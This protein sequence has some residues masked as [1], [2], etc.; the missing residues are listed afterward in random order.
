MTEHAVGTQYRSIDYPRIF[1]LGIGA[2]IYLLLLASGN[3]LLNDP[4]TYTHIALGRWIVEHRAVPYGD[5]LSQS[6]AGT[7]W[8]A[9]EWL[10]EVAYAAAYGAGGWT[11]VVILGAGAAAAAF[12]LLAHFLLR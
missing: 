12:A 1:A 7:H 4:D 5:A 3:A 6:M 11:G 10:S 9:F 2:A 8:V